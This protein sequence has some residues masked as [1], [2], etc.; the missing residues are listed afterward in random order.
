VTRAK[1]RNALR[2]IPLGGL[3][4]IGKNMT[5]FE[6]GDDMVVVDAG[7]MFPDAELPGVDLVLPDYSYILKNRERLRGIVITHGH[8]DHTGAL[9]YLLRDLGTPVPIL[10]SRLTCGL[11]E[12]KLAEFDIRKPKLR[13]V[14]PGMHVTLGAFGFDFVPTNHSI[15]DSL[16][17][18]IRTPVGTVLHTGDFKFD[19]TPV[20]GRGTDFAALT[21][22][23]R[24]GVLLMLSDSTGAEVRGFTHPE[25]EVGATLHRIIREAKGRVIVASFSSHIHRVQM[26]CDA[27]V[28][29]GRKVVVTGRSMLKNTGIAREL[30]F[31][32]IAPENILDAYEAT[33]LPDE[34][35]VILSTG[36][37]GEPLSG[38]TRMA[39]GDH[40]TITVREGDTIIISAS[41][42]PGNERAV[43]RVI[44]RLSKT[45]A[46][47][48][49]RG[50]AEVHV[51]GHAAAEE[52]KLMLAMVR[53]RFFM[54]V[55]GETRHLMAHSRL[56]ESVGI[57]PADIFAIE[58]GDVLELT[59]DRAKVS[60]HIKDSG[61]V[62]VDGLN[63]GDVGDV[64]L[65]DRQQ[66]SSD[67][68]AT[69][70]VAI[71]GRTRKFIGEPELVMRGL[72]VTETDRLM[73]EARARIDKALRRMEKE[74]VTDHSIIQRAVREAVSQFVWETLRRRPMVVPVIME[75]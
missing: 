52:L 67:G 16:A 1:N 53:P 50:V 49:H 23:G 55:H 25:R 56:A 14:K 37:Q 65:R 26:V 45:G 46:E 66:L 12:G 44:S 6:Y 57:A 30:G 41:P 4:E 72:P 59:A 70:V 28:D 36:S 71:D 35:I 43:S 24:D 11:I 54:P 22:A 21:K 13:V 74:G 3:D 47:V 48:F 38:L 19:Q 51:S 17:L 27:A 62:Y 39:N 7:L 61:V 68:I 63:V 15:P 75:V 58:N 31:L 32:T 29:A 10:G 73:D 8:E 34:E 60:E 20:D 64:V 69:V 5:V 33:D 9:P 2:V 18:I 42:I 40:R